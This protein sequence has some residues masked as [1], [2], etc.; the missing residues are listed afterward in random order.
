MNNVHPKNELYLFT[1]SKFLLIDLAVLPQTV[2][3]FLVLSEQVSISLDC[4]SQCEGTVRRL[5]FGDSFS[6][7]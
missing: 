4:K 1:V 7:L 2:I 6:V 3:I 5:Q